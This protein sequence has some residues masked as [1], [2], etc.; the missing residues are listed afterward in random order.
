M[1]D[2]DVFS[3]LKDFLSHIHHVIVEGLMLIDLLI[4][5]VFSIGE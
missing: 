2:M 5:L 3:I 1:A 4:R